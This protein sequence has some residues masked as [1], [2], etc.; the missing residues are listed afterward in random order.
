M[1]K[2]RELTTTTSL[3]VNDS[4]EGETIEQK[5]ERILNNEGGIEDGA[6]LIYSEREDDVLPE[7][8][9]RTDKWDIAIDATSNA[10]EQKLAQRAE[11]LERKR[12]GQ[13]KDNAKERVQNSTGDGKAEPTQGTE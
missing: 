11:R 1:Y 6:P 3:S 9:P 2:N 5:M 12:E 10:T 8:N 7:Y 4:V 13:I